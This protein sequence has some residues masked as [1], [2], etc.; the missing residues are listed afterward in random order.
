MHSATQRAR[1][2]SALNNRYSISRARLR[3]AGGYRLAQR[4]RGE[5]LTFLPQMALLD[6]RERVLAIEESNTPGMLIEAGCALGGSSIMLAA[7]KNPQRALKVYDVFSTIPPPSEKD[8]EDVTAR[9]QLIVEG[10]ATGFDGDVYYGYQENLE[11]K[12]AE[13]FERFGY[14]VQSNSISLIPGLFQDT[15][16]PDGPVALAHVDGDWYESVKVCLERIWPELSPGGV[17]VVDDYDAWTGCRLAVD[18]FISGRE[19]VRIERKA[20]LHLIRR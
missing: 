7:S 6:L 9:Y 11:Q 8:G 4:L 15:I 3:D 1:I 20:R 12:V 10:K 2:I 17:I 18:E 14:S 5:G 13:T 16:S 19:N